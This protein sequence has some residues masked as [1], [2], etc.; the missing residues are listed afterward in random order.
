MSIANVNPPTVSP[1]GTESP[2]PSPIPSTVKKHFP[3]IAVAVVLVVV[4]G[5]IAVIIFLPREQKVIQTQIPASSVAPGAVLT[6]AS[7]N[8]N[9][10]INVPFVWTIIATEDYK[11]AA[12]A[13]LGLSDAQQSAFSEYFKLAD[14]IFWDDKSTSA[15]RPVFIVRANSVGGL[16]AE[17]SN[18]KEFVGRVYANSEFTQDKQINF[19]DGGAHS[20]WARGSIGSNV[21]NSKYLLFEKNGTVFTLGLIAFESDWQ[22]N[23]DGMFEGVTNSFAL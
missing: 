14:T 1:S 6:F 19:K 23:F 8:Y 18:L 11:S 15:F 3:K 22:S 20:I 2:M 16:N 21:L 4:V 10:T 7:K 12:V 17:I 13:P 5:A 9:Y